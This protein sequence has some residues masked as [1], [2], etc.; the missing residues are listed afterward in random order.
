MKKKSLSLFALYIF[1]VLLKFIYIVHDKWTNSYDTANGIF[2]PFL[3]LSV[4]RIAL[5]NTIAIGKFY[6][7]LKFYLYSRMLISFLQFNWTFQL[8]Q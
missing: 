4:V 1:E 3:Q 6:I 8:S 7:F 2:I 5:S